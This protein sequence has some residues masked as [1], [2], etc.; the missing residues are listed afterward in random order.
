M[1]VYIQ[2]VK[3]MVPQKFFYQKWLRVVEEPI[4]APATGP[5]ANS[6]PLVQCSSH[7]SRRT[8][9]APCLIRGPT[10]WGIPKDPRIQE[11]KGF[12]VVH[13]YTSLPWKRLPVSQNRLSFAYH[14]CWLKVSSSSF[15][16]WLGA[17]NGTYWRTICRASGRP[18]DHAWPWINGAIWWHL[19]Y[20]FPQ[21]FPWCTGMLRDAGF[22]LAWSSIGSPS[23]H[24]GS[25]RGSLI[26]LRTKLHIEC[27]VF[28]LGIWKNYPSLTLL[29]PCKG[30]LSVHLSWLFIVCSSLSARTF[31]S[32][33]TADA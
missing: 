27:C 21:N 4:W 26:N 11:F 25:R 14:C 33:C 32:L 3:P 24:T 10:W 20:R 15:S 31:S 22:F 23:A 5:T 18:G 8:H 1:Y 29:S 17:T 2:M 7:T 6:K 28:F 13:W 12:G 19:P 9:C 16:A 30:Y